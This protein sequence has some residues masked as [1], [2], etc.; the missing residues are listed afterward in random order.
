[1]D[2]SVSM[3]AG[4]VPAGR[5]TRFRIGQAIF[6]YLKSNKNILIGFLVP[7][8]RLFKLNNMAEELFKSD[9]N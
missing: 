2:G 1:M 8:F 9:N 6:K 3:N 4:H 5:V 7:F